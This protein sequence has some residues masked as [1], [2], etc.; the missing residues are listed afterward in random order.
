MYN[1][2][3]CYSITILLAHVLPFFSGAVIIPKPAGATNEGTAGSTIGSGARAGDDSFPSP[4]A[5]TRPGS[6]S[7]HAGTLTG[8]D[9]NG[10]S[11]Q[12]ANSYKENTGEIFE[13]VLDIVKES[14]PDNNN[15]LSTA[16][17]LPGPVPTSAVTDWNARACLQANNIYSNCAAQTADFNRNNYSNQ[18]SCLCYWTFLGLPWLAA[19]DV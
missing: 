10:G 13:K 9:L 12:G 4:T 19:A 15:E 16:T 1:A 3:S 17:I 6:N 5:G 14:L 2:R 18:A 7:P 8:N 11:A